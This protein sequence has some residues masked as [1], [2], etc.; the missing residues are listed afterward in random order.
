MCAL[1]ANRKTT[2]MSQ[3]TICADI[4]QAL[5]V[6][7]HALAEIAL[8]LALLVEDGANAAQ[9]VLAQIPDPRV[10]AHLRLVQDRG[11]TRTSD[12]VNVCEADLCALVRRKINTSYTSHSLILQKDFIPDAVYAWGLC[13]S[14]SPRLC[15]G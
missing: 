6:H 2:A 11:R 9:L 10:N 8:N 13:R 14:L 3:A 1:S 15:G 12:S 4:H 7:L 5:D